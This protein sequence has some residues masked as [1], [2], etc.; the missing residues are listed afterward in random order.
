MIDRYHL[1]RKVCFLLLGL[2]LSACG[3]SMEKK[4]EFKEEM[5]ADRLILD[6]EEANRLVELPLACIDL[7]YPNKLGQVLGS[8]QDLLAPE[9]LHPAFYGCFD[10][11]SAVHGHWSL[12][13]LVRLYPD[14]NRR[15]E[16]M[17]KLSEHLTAENIDRE[18]DY[19]NN[20]L[21]GSFERMYGWAWLLKLAEELQAYEAQDAD[22]LRTSIEPLA[23]LIAEKV[24]AFL[25]RL[26]YPIRVGTH[27]NTAF[28][29]AMVYDYATAFEDDDLKKLVVQRAK[30]FYLEDVHCPMGWEPSGYDFLSPCLE[31]ADIMRRVLSVDTY[32]DWLH[33]FLPELAKKDFQ[34]EPGMV[35]DRKDGH[36]VHLDGLNFSRAWCLYGIVD[37]LPEYQHLVR[38][39]NDHVNYSL[40]NLID[41]SYEGGHWLASFALL[42]LT[43]EN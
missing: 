27:T 5:S 1:V 31:E 38:I 43:G 15:H 33:E 42:A 2:I 34:L 40:P 25:P 30:D 16:V 4:P 17:E 28:A 26:K 35:S 36:L 20:A 32:R 24:R 8:D 10:W 39:A 22:V 12:V 14:L 11:H 37:T 7:Q 21:N 3:I 18:I 6:K 9:K 19:F 23:Q 41:D 29:L 13:R